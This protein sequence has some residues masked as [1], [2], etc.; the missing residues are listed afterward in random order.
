MTLLDAEPDTATD[1]V[2]DPRSWATRTSA[3]I[4][5]GL[6]VGS[7]AVA[8]SLA[9][10]LIVLAT[11]ASPMEVSR[12]LYQ[13]SL[14]TWPAFGYTLEQA[15]P[16]MIVALG[17][18]ISTRSGLFN[19]GPEGQF[20]VGSAT[21]ALV[22]F[23]VGAPAGVVVPLALVSAAAGGALWAGVA[24][25]LHAVR[26]VDVII[27]TLL[28][29]FVALQ[30]VSFA[31]NR[32][33]LLQESTG[34]RIDPP[35][36]PLLESGLRLPRLGSPPG[37]NTSSGILVALLLAGVVGYAL[38]QTRW[39]F[40]LRMLGLNPLAARAAGVNLVVLGGGALMLSG[41]FAGLAGGVYFAGTG[42]RITAGAVGF[43]YNGLL[44][45]L[46]SR[47]RISAIV[48]L[49]LAFGA[50]RSGGGY[51]AAT[52]VPRYMVDIVQALIVFAAL[53]PP[54]VDHLRRRSRELRVAHAATRSG[55]TLAPG[56]AL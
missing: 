33:W 25:G 9:S 5:V 53:I 4:T 39:G 12:A 28:L 3:L 24:A 26:N 37:F 49:A 16:V 35:Q 8:L 36:S 10:V 21:G 22:I 50:L 42:Y 2:P 7:F 27:T 31:V 34:R 38:G 15:A 43:G 1:S 19:I 18:V 52:G 40:R 48:M 11:D 54:V 45:A 20:A 51:L 47:G 30:A 13:G 55:T 46:I 6:Y 17:S 41:G 44:V 32:H 56:A 23:H 29:N 14:K